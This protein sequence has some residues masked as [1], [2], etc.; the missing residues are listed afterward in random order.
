MRKWIL[1]LAAMVA[2]VFMAGQAQAQDLTCTGTVFND[3]N[4]GN[5]FCGWIEWFHDLGVTTGCSETPP[6]YC[7]NSLVTRA[8]M[9]AFIGRAMRGGHNNSVTFDNDTVGGGV[10]NWAKGGFSTVAGGYVNTAGGI[11]SAVAGGSYNTASG[12]HSIVAGGE[13]NTAAN[14]YTTIP[15][16]IQARAE[17]YGQM[18]YASGCF[19]ESPSCKGKAQ[20]SLYVLRNTTQGHESKELFLDG[21]AGQQRLTINDGQT[22][23]FNIMIAARGATGYSVGFRIWGVIKNVQGTVST[24]YAWGEKYGEEIGDVSA[25]AGEDNIHKALAIWVTGSEFHTMRWVATVQTAEV[26]Y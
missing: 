14:W 15:G 8:Q 4:S 11:D 5:F 3:V 1:L 18:A 7:P 6:L 16:G 26:A 23:T 17:R 9:A 25:T 2:T 22:M 19:N 21:E 13:Q 10:S 24:V 20:A 12:H